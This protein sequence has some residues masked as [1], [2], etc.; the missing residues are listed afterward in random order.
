[1]GLP[2]DHPV[3]MGAQLLPQF[4][5]PLGDG[6]HDERQ[7]PPPTADPADQVRAGH[8]VEDFLDDLEALDR[9][10][11]IIIQ[12]TTQSEN[13]TIVDRHGRLDLALVDDQSA[14]ILSWMRA[15]QIGQND[16]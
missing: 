15:V 1:M 5:L 2:Q 13:F 9:A 3:E 6:G 14:D 12:Q 7:R 8:L 11:L 4:F 10:P 16:D